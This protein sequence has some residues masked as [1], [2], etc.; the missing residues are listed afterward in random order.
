MSTAKMT[1]LGLQTVLNK[2]N[3]DLFSEVEL[4]EGIDLDTLKSNILLRGADF[5]VLYSDPFFMKDVFS[6]VSKKWYRTFEKW[7]DALAIEYAP[8]E[9]YDRNEDYTDITD[10]NITTS[11]SK[12][13]G[14]TRTFNNQDQ[15]TLN[16][17]DE[18]TLDLTDTTTEDVSA[19]DSST[20][21]PS[22]KTTLEQDGTDTLQ[23]TGTDTMNYSG[24][25]GDV[26]DEDTSGLE[27]EDNTFTHS[28]RIH[29]NVGVTTSQA[30]LAEE[31]R[32][33]EWNLYEH[34]TDVFLSETVIP[35]YS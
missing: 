17:E 10:R 3:D 22:K 29:G 4:P 23:R 12:D 11:G 15:R 18:R 9:N 26:Y 35:I 1:L 8:L 25:V 21:Q 28:G 19:Y 16:T 32:I 27:E 30:M 7:V 24:T 33:A 31:L 5:E 34:I 13:S 20:Y 2:L 6:L 14:N